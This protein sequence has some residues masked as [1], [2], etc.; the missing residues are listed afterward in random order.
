MAGSVESPLIEPLRE[1]GVDAG[2]ILR[3]LNQYPATM[4]QEWVDITLA[5]QERFGPR[6]FKR[7]PAAFLVDNIQ[8]AGTGSR[9]PPD[10]WQDLRRAERRAQSARKRSAVRARASNAKT[11]TD[12]TLTGALTEALQVQF[13]VAGQPAASARRNAAHVAQEFCQN[14]T[15]EGSGPVERLLQL[16]D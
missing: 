15:K 2:V 13:E 4:I 1:I 9:T 10:W 8:H 11:G 16:L 14:H 5:A 7:S 6:Y 3:L 12:D